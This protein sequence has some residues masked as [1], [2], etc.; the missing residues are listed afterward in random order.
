LD[1]VELYEYLINSSG[2][3]RQDEI[4]E[5][6]VSEEYKDVL[7]WMGEGRSEREDVG[8]KGTGWWEGW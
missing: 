3:A 5:S 7:R 8:W 6:I 2:I 4:D 1:P